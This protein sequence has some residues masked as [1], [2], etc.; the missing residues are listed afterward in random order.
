MF[1]KIFSRKPEPQPQPEPQPESELVVECIPSLTWVLTR[2]EQNKGSPLT[3]E[4]VVAISGQAIAIALPRK[5]RDA[6]WLSQG[7]RDISCES[8]W[9]DWQR[10]KADPDSFNLS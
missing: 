8:P 7:N 3:E 9:K 10:Y 5:E 2:A 6:K 1:R 4:E